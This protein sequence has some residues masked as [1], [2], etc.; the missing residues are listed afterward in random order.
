[1]MNK[2]SG[3]N[4]SDDNLDADLSPLCAFPDWTDIME[5]YRDVPPV[6]FVLR[7]GGKKPWPVADIAEQLHCYPRAAAKLG[8]LH[9]SGMIYLREPLEQSSGFAA[10]SFRVREWMAMHFQGNSNAPVVAD[11]TGGLGID[12]AVWALAGCRVYYCERNR[13]LA[14]LARHN[15]RLLGLDDRIT[16]IIGDGIEWLEARIGSGDPLP[17]LLYID[18]SRRPDSRRVISLDESEPA[19][20]TFMPLITSS[21]RGYLLKLSPMLDITQMKRMLSGLHQLTA[22]SVAGEVKELLAEGAEGAVAAESAEGPGGGVESDS[23]KIT[24]QAVV[25][26]KNGEEMFRIA[27][28]SPHEVSDTPA[29]LD[30]SD[31]P[32]IRPVG[33]Y[34]YEPDPAILKM[35]LSGQLT[36][37]FQLYYVNRVTGYLTG[38]NFIPDFPGRKYVVQEFHPW[39]PKKMRRMLADKG[40]LRVHIHQRGFPLSVNQ[41]FD[42]LGCMMGDDAHLIATPDHTGQ[43]ML[44]IAN[45]P[46]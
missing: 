21:A 40:L 2:K 15:H 24:I 29:T 5:T 14:L 30:T 16:H 45:L 3:E 35:G 23:H 19:V 17:D 8:P 10:A 20:H 9:K 22:V 44:I 37:K 6:E 28:D 39:K 38:D 42:T 13:K 43:L 32:D 31:T 27:I 41:L 26:S 1:M 7:F 18:P 46:D 34:L 12:S 11:I 36:M 25:L 33:K 4:H